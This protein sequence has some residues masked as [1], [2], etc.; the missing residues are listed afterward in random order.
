MRK[1]DW[2][3][4]RPAHG[5]ELGLTRRAQITGLFSAFV[6]VLLAEEVSVAQPRRRMAARDWIH[7]QDELARALRRGQLAP[8]SWMSEV[9]RLA[10]EIDVAE[11]MADVNAARL[12]AASPPTTHDPRKR[13][14]RFLDDTG[15]PRRLAYG[16]A[17]FDFSPTHVITPHGHRHM[18]SAHLVVGGSFRIRNFDRLRDERDAMVIRPTRDVIAPVGT[19]SAMS[20]ERDN[21]HWFVPQGGP[22]RTFDVVI[23]GLDAGQPDHDIQAIDPLG[24]RRLADGSIVAP[25]LSFEAASAKYDASV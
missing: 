23:S 11:L 10:R 21:I 2:T 25:L 4:A 19:L 8:R 3:R 18:V 1:L 20:S 6:T 9:E 15:E 13:W 24:G 5:D 14:V 22:A 16:A 7:R 17:L 12:S